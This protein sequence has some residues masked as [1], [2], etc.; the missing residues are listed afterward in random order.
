MMRVFTT[1]T[2]Y[3]L[4]TLIELLVVIAI[5]AILMCLLLPALKNVKGLAARSNC[6]NNLKQC[7]LAESSYLHDYNDWMVPA[8]FAPSG[9]SFDG[10]TKWVDLISSYLAGKSY[11][12]VGNITKTLVCPSNLDERYPDDGTNYS[13]QIYVGYTSGGVAYYTWKRV[14]HYSTPSLSA[15]MADGKPKA[16]FLEAGNKTCYF[17]YT[18]R[19]AG[20]H[21]GTANISYVDGHVDSTNPLPVRNMEY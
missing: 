10:A 5:I 11:W 4:F 8:Y 7:A 9:S 20:C 1:R 3:K 21:N 18:N 2:R 12:G 13:Y 6:S 19:V 17:G 15:V 16:L 14:N